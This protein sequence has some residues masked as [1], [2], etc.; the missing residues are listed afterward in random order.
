MPT[1][2]KIVELTFLLFALLGYGYSAGIWFILWRRSLAGSPHAC[3]LVTSTLFLLTILEIL[4][5]TT[6]HLHDMGVAILFLIN[7]FFNFAFARGYFK[8]K[9]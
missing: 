4:I 6:N 2:L 1:V 7:S 9:E 5:S 3:F 8:V